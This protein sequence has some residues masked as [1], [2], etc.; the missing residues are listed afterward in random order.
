MSNIVRWDPFREMMSLRQMMNRVFDESFNRQ[1]GGVEDWNGPSVDMYQTDKELVIKAVMP[2]L[3]PED[4]DITV[5]GDVLTLRG[6]V[7]KEQ[8]I[9]EANYHLQ[10]RHY[11]SFSRSIPLPVSVVT[12]QAHAEFEN[13][14]LTLT[15]PKSEIDRPKTISV[16]VK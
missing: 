1:L 4:I 9:K 16:K 15:L 6:E 10:E 11:G 13:G 7:K 5:T 2:G 14:I 8:E 12:D 3:K